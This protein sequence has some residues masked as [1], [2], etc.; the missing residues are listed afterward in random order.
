MAAD[1][2]SYILSRRERKR[3]CRLSDGKRPW[4][5]SDNESY[6][7]WN[8]A[9]GKWWIDEPSGAGKY[10]VFSDGELPPARGWAALPG[11]EM[12]LPTVEIVEE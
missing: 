4:F 3:P 8:R 2:L 6:V 12:P 1:S 10:I 11:A 5:E 9:D 7:Y